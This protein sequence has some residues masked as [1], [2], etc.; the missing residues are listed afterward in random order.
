MGNE[1]GDEGKTYALES[2]LEF[3]HIPQFISKQP[4]DT[5]GKMNQIVDRHVFETN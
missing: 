4:K 2:R 3:P 1:V 5:Q